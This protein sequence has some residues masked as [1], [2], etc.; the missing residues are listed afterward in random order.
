MRLTFK[1]YKAALITLAAIAVLAVSLTFTV[2]RLLNVEEDLRREETHANLWQVSQTQ[3]EASILAESLARAAAGE[4]FADREQTPEFR[5]A[6]LISRMAI[7]MD[8]LQGQVIEK[9]GALGSLRDAYLQLTY[10]EPLLKDRIDPQTA[11]LL[12]V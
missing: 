11:Q 4:T 1:N 12:R 2:W 7:L 6:I 9:V 5:L 3:F 8:G 10:A